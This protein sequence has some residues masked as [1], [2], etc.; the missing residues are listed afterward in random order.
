MNMWLGQD[1]AVLRINL[2]IMSLCILTL[3]GCMGPEVN[4]GH[5]T[6]EDV[7]GAR[8]DPGLQLY[9]NG[10]E[11]GDDKPVGY[12]V[13]NRGTSP[14]Y[15]P[16]YTY[17]VRAYTFDSQSQT[18]VYYPWSFH[19]VD[20]SVV[21]ISPGTSKSGTNFYGIPMSFLPPGGRVRLA[22]VDWLDP[23][24]PDGTKVAAYADVEIVR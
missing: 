24:N 20:P 2:I 11:F 9:T 7:V 15:F 8:L 4:V 23:N 21:S 5:D 13:I 17:G 1:R 19:L 3:A 16:D 10:Y 18:W 6:F 12:E 22:V 14:V